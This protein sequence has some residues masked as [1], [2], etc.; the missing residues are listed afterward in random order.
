LIAGFNKLKEKIKE[1]RDP[2]LA[3]QKQLRKAM[4]TAGHYSS[5]SAAVKEL[6]EIQGRSQKDTTAE[7]RRQTRLY[8]RK[9]LQQRLQHLQAVRQSGNLQQVIF[10]LRQDL[11][12]N[13]GNMTNR[14][15]FF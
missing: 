10:A 5:W 13:L 15:A 1:L 4:Q 6:A 12:R 7:W 9:L 14:C 8:D 11:L 3:R 2:A